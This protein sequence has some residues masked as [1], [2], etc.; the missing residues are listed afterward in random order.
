MHARISVKTTSLAMALAFAAILS[1]RTTPVFAEDSAAGEAASSK[2]MGPGGPNGR[3]KPA[4]TAK[5][6]KTEK[7]AS[8][9]I[10]LARRA[11]VSAG[12]NVHD[13]VLSECNLETTLPQ[14]VAEKSTKVT[15]VDSP[16]G[17]HLD[18]RIVDVHAPN[19]GFFSG[20]KWITVE[21]KLMS[22]KS[23]KGDFT[24][25][26]SSMASATACGML[27]K[28]MAVIAEDIATWLENPTKGARLTHA[29]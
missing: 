29:R 21:G 28:V 13:K 7:P 23:V 3:S 22:G 18:L 20:P 11:T 9:G 12:I 14:L 27:S 19:G 4:S 17:T 1:I 24:V 26:E 6:E 25:K 8:S 15:L 10:Q 5:A 16:S 2:P